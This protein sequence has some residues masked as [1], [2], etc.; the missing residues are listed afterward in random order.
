MS[1]FFLETII[2]L[3]LKLLQFYLHD[4]W[5]VQWIQKMTIT[6][7][8][9]QKS[10]QNKFLPCKKQLPN[11]TKFKTDNKIPICFDRKQIFKLY[12]LN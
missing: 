11:K 8:E 4:F 9:K 12:T 3:Y 2:N 10:L 5:T 7:F 1:E 6:P